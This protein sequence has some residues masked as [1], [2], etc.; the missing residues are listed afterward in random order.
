M[1]RKSLSAALVMIGILGA[2]GRG[3]TP[4][5]NW[6]SQRAEML[7]YFRDLV[8]IDTSNPPGNEQKVVEYLKSVL[9]KEGIPSQT[10]ARDP[11]RPNLVARLKGNGSARPLLMLAH[12]DVVP[13]QRDK[14]AVDPFAAIVKDGYIWGR[15]TTDDKDKLTANLMTLLLVK[16]TGL[17]LDRDLIFLAESAE[18]FDTPGVGM[19]FM[20]DEHFDAIDAE[21]AITEGP[22]A[23]IE[24]G[25]AT[26][27]QI[28]QNVVC[29]GAHPVSQRAARWLLITHDRAGRDEFQLTQEFLGQMLGSRRPT[30][31]ETASR[32]QAQGLIRYSRGRV[33]IISRP[34]LEEASC[35]CYA[36]VK[37]EFDALATG[38]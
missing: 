23:T 1:H 26:M 7:R 29:N 24:N 18:E 10:F 9:D 32:L 17:P 11:N 13:V 12:T 28:A 27:V 16:R 36:I 6:K 33:T 37:A 19:K 35:P 21:F 38:S 3:Q 34:G 15:G 30:V 22:G 31:S 20:V 5:V 14:W 2:V 4:S 8:Q 25:R